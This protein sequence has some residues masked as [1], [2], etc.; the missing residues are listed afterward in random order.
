MSHGCTSL[1]EQR[2]QATNTPSRM[3]TIPS[4]FLSIHPGWQVALA[5][6]TDHVSENISQL[7]DLTKYFKHNILL[8]YHFSQLT[9]INV[10]S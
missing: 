3:K 7:F 6:I 1:S 9:E 5:R 8:C 2:V 4:P 10:I